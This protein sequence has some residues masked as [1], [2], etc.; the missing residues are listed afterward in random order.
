MRFRARFQVSSVGEIVVPMDV[1]LDTEVEAFETFNEWL[2]DN[3][4][5]W[6]SVLQRQ[7]GALRWDTAWFKVSAVNGFVLERTS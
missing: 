3:E 5:G 6:K 2:R 7:T 4:A 1:N